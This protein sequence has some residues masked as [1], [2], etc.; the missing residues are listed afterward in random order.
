DGEAVAYRL[1]AQ[2][3]EG[4]GVHGADD[5]FAYRADLARA[6]AAVAGEPSGDVR[7]QGIRC[8]T[9][10]REHEHALLVGALGDPRG[11]RGGEQGGLTRT[12]CAE[13]T[14]ESTWCGQQPPGT[15]VPRLWWDR[16]FRGPHESCLKSAH[17]P[18]ESCRPGGSAQP[19]RECCALTSV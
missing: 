9:G 17:D 16:W 13:H 15:V 14:H 6:F 8:L 4:V 19:G 7:A 10:R 5:G 18:M 3:R 12:R 11:G 1:Q 2:H